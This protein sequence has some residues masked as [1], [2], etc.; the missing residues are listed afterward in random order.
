M[1]DIEFYDTPEEILDRMKKLLAI[2]GAPDFETVHKTKHGDLRDMYVS[3]AVISVL[4]KKYCQIICKDITNLKKIE[5]KL[6]KSKQKYREAF[7]TANFYRDILTHDISNILQSIVIYIDFFNTLK[8]D[9]VKNQIGNINDIIKF[10][11]HRIAALISNIRTLSSLQENDF[12]LHEI[13]L[14]DVLNKANENIKKQF[15]N[16]NININ[17]EGLS[18]EQKIVA[19][20]LLITVFK[21]IIS[22]AI[23]HND[24]T[25]N[26]EIQIKIANYKVSNVNYVKMEFIDNGRGILDERKERLFNRRYD[27]DP[28]K[29]GMGLGL[30]LVHKIIEKY[31]GKIWIEDRIK[32]DY[33]RGSKVILLFRKE[34]GS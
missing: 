30:T 11:A 31:G 5:E 6:R 33:R 15:P 29:R 34:I 1:S 19:N 13:L 14:Y 10:H 25:N 18:V 2:G 7:Y 23:I 22:N 17:V 4:G 27:E 12:Q 28:S 9:S 20:V 32:D 16:K 3:I 8:K 26:I 24:N 21:N